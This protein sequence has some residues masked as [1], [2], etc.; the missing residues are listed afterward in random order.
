MNIDMLAEIGAFRDRI[1]IT[2]EAARVEASK[3]YPT[4]IPSDFFRPQEL[5]RFETSDVLIATT[6]GKFMEE[7]GVND[8]LLSR[9][10]RQK[11][12]WYKPYRE[13]EYIL[14]FG[15]KDRRMR[16]HVGRY[17]D[18]GNSVSVDTLNLDHTPLMVPPRRGRT[19]IMMGYDAVEAVTYLRSPD[20]TLLTYAKVH[21]PVN[22]RGVR[23][24]LTVMASD[25]RL[26][27]ATGQLVS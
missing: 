23:A 12:Y 8:F 27:F 16:Y 19:N 10:F 7:V 18:E 26:P 21:T 14:N 6:V 20:S 9:E 25:P 4:Q 1:S 17:A 5:A 13:L 2:Q 11:D 15:G 3:E 22:E 24:L